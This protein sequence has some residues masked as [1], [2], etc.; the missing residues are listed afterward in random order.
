VPHW[1]T[2]SDIGPRPPATNWR[3]SGCSKCLGRRERDELSRALQTRTSWEGRCMGWVCFAGEYFLHMLLL[4][5]FLLFFSLCSFSS[6]SFP[7]PLPISSR[8]TTFASPPIASSTRH[9]RLVYPSLFLVRIH[10]RRGGGLSLKTVMGRGASSFASLHILHSFLIFLRS[11]HHSYPNHPRIPA[12]RLLYATS[13]Q[14]IPPSSSCGCTSDEEV[15]FCSSTTWVGC[16][17]GGVPLL[18]TPTSCSFTRETH[19]RRPP[20][21]LAVLHAY[22]LLLDPVQAGRRTLAG[23]L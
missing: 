11:Y 22:R 8:Q 19:P 9:H 6:N 10:E 3:Q 2:A 18:P 20:W 16:T 17:F 15:T 7:F 23:P 13:T 4:S 14:S 5:F 12:H 1:P 21:R